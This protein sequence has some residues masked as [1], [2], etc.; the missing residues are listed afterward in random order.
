[1]GCVAVVLILGRIYWWLEAPW[2]GPT[3]AAA[4]AALTGAVI[5]E[6]NRKAPLIDVRWLAS[7]AIIHFAGA[8]LIF[9]VVLA[10]QTTGASGFFQML[11][12]SNEQ[13]ADMWVLVPDAMIAGGPACACA[14]S[15]GQSEHRIHAVALTLVATGAWLAS[16]AT[17]LTRAPDMYLS[18]GMIA[19]RQGSSCRQRRD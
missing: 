10:E 13:L 12:L 9:R 19:F 7:P 1:M 15:T 18:Q 8:L 11:G 3:L 17:V 16:S 5:I 4:G 6:L 14:M 2:I